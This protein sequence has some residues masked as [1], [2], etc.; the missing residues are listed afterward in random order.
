MF[1]DDSGA[2][3]VDRVV[4]TAA[5]VIVGGVVI[6]IIRA[7]LLDAFAAI[8][9]TLVASATD[10]RSSLSGGGSGPK[11]FSDYVDAAGGDHGGSSRRHKCRRA[12]WLSIFRWNETSTG[13]PLNFGNTEATSSSMSLGRTTYASGELQDSDFT[14]VGDIKL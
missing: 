6:G 3:I 14:Y 1:K 11:S 2:D 4:R 12:R 5:L 7:G 9:E 13:T 10:L 8:G